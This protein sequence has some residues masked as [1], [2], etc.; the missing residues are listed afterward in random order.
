MNPN[1]EQIAKLIEKTDS[2]T[3]AEKYVSWVA[4]LNQNEQNVQTPFLFLFSEQNDFRRGV[5]RILGI[6]SF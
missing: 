2:L 5:A 3:Y 6:F 4:F 1:S